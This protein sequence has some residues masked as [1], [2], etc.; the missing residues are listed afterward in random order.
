VQTR[1][2]ASVCPWWLWPLLCLLLALAVL[3]L[4]ALLQNRG[5]DSNIKVNAK[6]NNTVANTEVDNENETD[7][8]T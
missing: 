2:A 7:T 3:G 1:Q 8:Q 5:T 6:A 4:F